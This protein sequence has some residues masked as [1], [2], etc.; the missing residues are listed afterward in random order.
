[1]VVLM[2]AGLLAAINVFLLPGFMKMFEEMNLDLPAFTKLYLAARW[3][4]VVALLLMLP[5]YPLL[6]RLGRG[7]ALLVSIVAAGLFVAFTTLALFLPLISIIE[8]R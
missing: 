3:P 1:M 4:L 2:T 5:A 8:G 6:N 7:V